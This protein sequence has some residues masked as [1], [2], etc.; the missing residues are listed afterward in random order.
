MN[1]D[2]VKVVSVTPI[3]CQPQES[4]QQIL[5]NTA[6]DMSSVLEQFSDEVPNGT[7]EKEK[8]AMGFLS[9]LK[10]YMHSAEF[11]KDIEEA[12]KKHGIPPKQLAKNFFTKALGVVGDILGIAISAVCNAGHMIIN[13]ASTIAHGIVELISNIANAVASMVTF[14]QTCTAH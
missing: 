11:K 6:Q 12:S 5:H 4:V 9:Q 2:N 8:K 14:N 3:S 7:T 1:S 13:I 10:G